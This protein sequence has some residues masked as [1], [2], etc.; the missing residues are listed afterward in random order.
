[1]A[2]SFTKK[3][4]PEEVS[5]KALSLDSCYFLYMLAISHSQWKMRSVTYSQMTYLCNTPILILTTS[6][7]TKT[8]SKMLLRT[9]VE[10]MKCLFTLTKPDECLYVQDKKKI[11]RDKLNNIRQ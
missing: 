11:S 5:H 9:G 1:M 4:T 8:L 7:V 10:P 6:S 2:L 3:D